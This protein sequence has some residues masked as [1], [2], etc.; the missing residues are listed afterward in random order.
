[1]NVD[2]VGLGDGLSQVG[3]VLST[4]G[5]PPSK[6]GAARSS[7]LSEPERHLYFWILRRFAA[8]GRPSNAETRHAAGELGLDAESALGTF[9][10]QELVHLD[11]SGE[12]DVA[13]P[14]SG[15]PTAHRV[16]FPSGH[17]AYAMCAIDAL[18]IAPMLGEPIEIA[19]R[20]PLTDEDIHVELEPGG[21]GSWQPEQ[22]VV[23]AGR[24][25]DSE[26][27]DACCP[28]LNFFASTTNAERWLAAH[29]E[30]QGMVISM[31]DAIVAGRAV[32]SDILKEA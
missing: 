26:S 3:D 31:E 27:C 9:A 25:G 12:I 2:T 18:G 10:T 5:I 8:G 28:V 23:V 17:E 21:T 32:F 14:F 13:Y 11:R 19:S 30:V 22:A 4:A 15:R 29:P 24:A 20:D 6:L 16:R 7:R 1:M